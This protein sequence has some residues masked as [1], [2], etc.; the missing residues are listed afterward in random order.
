MICLLKML[1]LKSRIFLNHPSSTGISRGRLVPHSWKTSRLCSCFW[2][3]HFGGTAFSEFYYTTDITAP[4]SPTAARAMGTCIGIAAPEIEPVSAEVGPPI[5]APPVPATT[6]VTAVATTVAPGTPLVPL[7]ISWM[8]SD[9][10]LKSVCAREI[11]LL[12]RS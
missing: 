6:V 5:L 4:T 7:V 12:A 8:L 3:T 10:E 2:C 11:S 1:R 9:V